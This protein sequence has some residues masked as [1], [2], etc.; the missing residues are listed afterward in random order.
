[1][2]QHA[3]RAVQA[4]AHHRHLTSVIARRIA[5]L[6]AGLV[7]L[8]HDHGTEVVHGGEYRGTRA[9]RDLALPPL[10][11]EPRVVALAV[12]ERGMEHRHAIAEHGTEAIHR[13]R[14]EGD[15]R[16]EHYR[17]LAAAQDYL[18]EHFQVY[19]GLAAPGHSVKQ[20]R[21]TRRGIPDG[22]D[23]LTLGGGRIVPVLPPGIAVNEGIA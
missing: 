5:L 17:T 3:H 10:Q 15:L 14:R 22:G 7:L 19:E 4:R 6:V 9:Y 18:P 1:R 23:R 2:S 13:L 8:V 21:G 16:H 11:R 12:R 20:E